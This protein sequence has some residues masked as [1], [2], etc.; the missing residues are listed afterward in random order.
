MAAQAFKTV[1][2]MNPKF[3]DAASLYKT[4]VANDNADYFLAAGEKAE[5]SKSWDRAV[6]CYQRA[7][8]Y[9]PENQDLA[10]KLENLKVKV[11]QIFFDEA[12]KLASHEKLWAAVGKIESVKAYLP[13]MKDEQVFRD[14]VARTTT[15]LIARGDRYNDKEMWGNA[16]MWYQKAE[17]LSPN[18]PELFQKVQDTRERIGKRIRKSIAVFDFSS[19]SNDKDAGK[20][21]ADKLVSYLYQKASSDLRIIERETSRTSSGRCSSARPVSL[22]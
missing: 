14:L 17:S 3:L 12:E 18:H 4:S 5:K 10:K 21:A 20:M 13:S 15:R 2:E 7:L 16:L 9:Q 19:P 1:M 6:F 8:E 11:G 22:T